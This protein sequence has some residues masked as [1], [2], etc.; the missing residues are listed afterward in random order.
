MIH[1][2]ISLAVSNVIVNETIPSCLIR[3]LMEEQRNCAKIRGEESGSSVRNVLDQS[4]NSEYGGIL[5][6]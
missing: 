2:A 4:L 6:N 3:F 5:L 1:G